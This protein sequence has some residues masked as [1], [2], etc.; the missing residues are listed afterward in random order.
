MWKNWKWKKQKKPFSFKF[1]ILVFILVLLGA[2]G[3]VALNRISTAAINISPYRETLA[4]DSR[5]RA[6]ANPATTGLS[7]ETMR[8]SSEESGLGYRYRNFFRRAKSERQN[9]RL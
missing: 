9:N 3:Y 7:F 2:F 5:L 8:L 1:A 4:I 6:Y